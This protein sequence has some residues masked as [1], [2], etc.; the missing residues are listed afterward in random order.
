MSKLDSPDTFTVPALANVATPSAAR[1]STFNVEASTFTGA[2][3]GNASSATKLKTARKINGTSFNGTGDITTAN[4]GTT[5][6][7]TVGNTA[8]SVNGSGNYAWSLSEIGA[9]PLSG[10]TMTGDLV[11]KNV[12]LTDGVY[13]RIVMQIF[14]DGDENNYGSEL[15]VGGAG[16]SFF[17]SGEAPNNLRK[18]YQTDGSER[19]GLEAYS[20]TSENT[21]IAADTFIHLIAGCG[22]ITNRNGFRVSSNTIAPLSDYNAYL[23]STSYAFINAY[24]RYWSLQYNGVNYGLLRVNAEGTASTVG[25]SDLVLGNST[26]SGTDGNARG[27][28]FLYNSNA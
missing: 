18:H 5:R 15:V 19:L 10:G 16:N 23:G 6:T 4:W 22:T 2:L 14:D 1:Q 8:K 27:R 26:I 12:K 24:S 9:V 13:S 17:G 20:I 21:Y 11:M 3:S 25:T 7:I 28:L